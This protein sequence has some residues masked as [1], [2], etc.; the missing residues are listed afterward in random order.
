MVLATLL[1][2][3][4]SARSMPRSASTGVHIGVIAQREDALGR[5]P[6]GAAP[7]AA[8]TTGSW[9]SGAR[10]WWRATALIHRSAI[11]SGWIWWARRTPSGSWWRPSPRRSGPH[12]RIWRMSTTSPIPTSGWSCCARPT[13][14]GC[15]SRSGERGCRPPGRR[16]H[17][18]RRTGAT[19]GGSCDLGR[20]WEIL[21]WSLY[22]V[23]RR[24]ADRMRIGRVLLAGDAAHQNSPLGRHG[25][26]LRHPGRHLCGTTPRRRCGTAVRTTRVLDEYDVNRRRVAT[27]YVQTDSHANWLA[28][29]EP[30]PSRRAA[31]QDELRATA[32][33]P[34]LHRAKVATIG[35]DRRHPGESIDWPRLPPHTPGG[36]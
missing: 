35:D 1:E 29:R 16:L 4:S 5:R 30:D 2:E 25:H 13:T 8:P 17:G 10:G 15:C 14:G 20:P 36:S 19:H 31:L 28:L 3:A 6:G 9:R 21:Q 12:V 22:V 24:V 7:G 27:E 32:A 26:E 33:D 34:E 23:S 11:P 18:A